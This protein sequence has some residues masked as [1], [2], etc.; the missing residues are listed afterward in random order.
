MLVA[1]SPN[2]VFETG[3]SV[4]AIEKRCK[5][6]DVGCKAREAWEA[7]QRAARELAE[8]VAAEARRIAAEI[9]ARIAAAARAAA[10]AVAR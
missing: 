3:L 10:E 5:W 9:A 4:R 1:A 8:R 2:V 7:V 6:W